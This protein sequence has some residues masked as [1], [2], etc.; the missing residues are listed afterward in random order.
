[1]NCLRWFRRLN[2]QVVVVLVSPVARSAF[3]DIRR[4]GCVARSE[5]IEI[6][7]T[8]SE[9]VDTALSALDLLSKVQPRRFRIVTS[10]LRRVAFEHGR[11]T[12]KHFCDGTLFVQSSHVLPPNRLAAYMYRVALETMMFRRFGWREVLLNDAR[13]KY[14]VFR[15]ELDLMRDL[16][17]SREYLDEQRLFL[18]QYAQKLKT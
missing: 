6:A 15:K 11:F 12:W 1:M 18:Q 4:T 10:W 17:C 14:S 5:G 13:A 3:N 16:N 9:E 7:A 8:S 2:A